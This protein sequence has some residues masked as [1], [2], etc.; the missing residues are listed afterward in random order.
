MLLSTGV[1]VGRPAQSSGAVF[2][3]WLDAMPGGKGAPGLQAKYD[4][5]AAPE[6]A[7]CDWL[8]SISNR[9]L[10]Y[11]MESIINSKIMT[12]LKDM[13]SVSIDSGRGFTWQEAIT[14]IRKELSSRDLLYSMCATHIFWEDAS[15]LIRW[16]LFHKPLRK[17]CSERTLN[18][19]IYCGLNW[20]W[21]KFLLPSGRN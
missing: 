13:Y 10:L 9:F 4:A 7:Q 1:A 2:V 21:V 18:T 14:Y 20:L 6:R 16:L 15:I 19:Q 3:F 17:Q 12:T 8:Q 5:I 11:H